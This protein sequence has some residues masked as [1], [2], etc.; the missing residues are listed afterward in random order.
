M[1]HTKKLPA[2][3][4][5]ALLLALALCVGL[6]VPALA[7][8]E[9]ESATP[10]ITKQPES[11]TVTRGE[12]FEFTI[13]AEIP[14]GDEVG[15]QWFRKGYDYVKFVSEEVTFQGDDQYVYFPSSWILDIT[16]LNRSSKA[17]Y[18]CV[19]YNLNEGPEGP[20]R[21]M[22]TV[23]SLEVRRNIWGRALALLNDVFWIVFVPLSGFFILS[24]LFLPSLLLSAMLLRSDEVSPYTFF[25][26]AIK[27]SMSPFYLL[28]APVG[29]PIALLY[30][31]IWG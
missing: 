16:D 26:L 30:E 5:L 3:R 14:N 12:K 28:I 11:V 6:G 25:E 23:V 4:A 7:E 20:N 27:F 10:V 17:E 18:Y 21:I 15:Y 22:S 8:E 13:E 24:P 2:L 31:L 1:N 9:E 19:V 29:Y